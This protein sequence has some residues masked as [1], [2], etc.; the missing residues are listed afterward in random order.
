MDS[1]SDIRSLQ[2][3]QYTELQ[4]PLNLRILTLIPGRGD[5]D[6]LRCELTEWTKEM[7]DEREYEALSWCWGDGSDE[8]S[9]RVSG[10]PDLTEKVFK[11]YEHLYQAIRALRRKDRQRHLWI[12]ALCINQKNVNE[13][14]QQVPRMDDIYGGAG[15]VCI[16]L[17]MPDDTS[18]IALDFINTLLK[19]IWNFDELCEDKATLPKWTALSDLLKRPWF[20]RRW[21]VQ[22]I[23]LAREGTVY[24]G[25]R[26]VTWRAFV[27]AVSLFVQVEETPKKLSALVKKNSEEYSHERNFFEEIPYLAATE[28]VKTTKDLFRKTP[29]GYHYR[30]L[31]LESLV[32]RLAVFKSS[33]PRDTVYALLAMARDS[34]P[35]SPDIDEEIRKLKPRQRKL[36][37]KVAAYFP[38][39]LKEKYQVEYKSP[40]IDVYQYF[41]QFS[42][43]KAEPTRALDVICRPFAQDYTKEQDLEFDTETLDSLSDQEKSRK[44][45]LP[46]WMP[47]VSECPFEMQ[48]ARRST[49]PGNAKAFFTPRMDRRYGD[50]F[51]GTPEQRI[52]SAAGSKAFNK[53]TLRFKKAEVKASSEIRHYSM[54]VEGFV[55]DTILE[56]GQVAMSGNLPH[57]WLERIGWTDRT[58]DPPHEERWEAFW[59]TLVADRDSNGGDPPIYYQHACLAQLRQATAQ[60]SFV[61]D[62][63]LDIAQTPVTNFLRRM[64]AIIF[65]RCLIETEGKRLGLAKDKVKKE[66]L[67]CI[68][69][70]C[71]VPVILR[72]IKKEPE[73]VETEDREDDEDFKEREIKAANLVKRIF[74]KRRANRKAQ[75]D[76]GP[77]QFDPALQRHKPRPYWAHVYRVR[78]HIRTLVLLVL[79]IWAYCLDE[80]LTA[81]LVSLTTM[82]HLVSY[83][84]E[85]FPEP[86]L[87]WRVTL[88]DIIISTTF[89]AA[90]GLTVASLGF[91]YPAKAQFMWKIAVIC[92]VY[93][94]LFPRQL[95]RPVRRYLIRVQGSLDRALDRCKS[96]T[97]KNLRSNPTVFWTLIRFL[98]RKEYKA[99]PMTKESSNPKYYYHFEGECYIHGMMNGEAIELQNEKKIPAEVFEIR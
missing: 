34:Q 46:T 80:Q 85:V 71:S 63:W 8:K 93:V 68:L 61:T 41:I 91:L 88:W 82:V 49:R 38:K 75:N 87:S 51:V 36:L 3:Y 15:N 83:T 58:D 16:W 95:P 97:L 17:G 78:N 44:V 48:D 45:K 89:T 76:M 43:R 47:S 94:G 9:I 28:L 54:F 60:S 56:Q 32:S 57:D 27:D 4:D 21:V 7:A 10:G 72:K 29:E 30:Q 20:T 2:P 69:Y 67:V 52:Y 6:V 25:D 84:T 77:A 31:S 96:V 59:R 55:L 11:I 64:K 19:G 92:S 98:T 39:P 5:E 50:L 70:G 65:E 42:I 99:E 90:I 74:E 13:R 26:S 23:S 35:F 79:T 22:E 40:I 18:S 81:A 12:D 33:Q 66:D 37:R 14:N 62:N 53:E 1:D 86:R 24:C 73:E